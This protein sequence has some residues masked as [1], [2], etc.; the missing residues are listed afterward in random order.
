MFFQPLLHLICVVGWPSL[1]VRCPPKLLYPSLP[2]HRIEGKI[3]PKAPGP[4]WGQGQITHPLQSYAK[5]THLKE[6]N[7][8]YYQSNLNRVIRNKTKFS[9]SSLSSL[10]SFQAQLHSQLVYLLPSSGA[11][12]WRLWVEISSKYVVCCFFLFIL[13]PCSSMESLLWEMFFSQAAPA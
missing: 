13:F 5:Q 1:D 8:I 4:R 6:R 7:V 2:K 3:Q 9:N 12:G 10:L 11:G